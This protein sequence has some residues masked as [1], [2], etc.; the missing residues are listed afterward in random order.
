MPPDDQHSNH[1]RRSCA[2][3]R[4]G[5]GGG[6]PAASR[7][8]PLTSSSPPA[9]TTT[10][11]L[12]LITVPTGPFPDSPI[13]DFVTRSS[14]QSSSIRCS[15]STTPNR[16]PRPATSSR[17]VADRGG[18]S[19]KLTE[20]FVTEARPRA[21]LADSGVPARGARL[22]VASG[23][24]RNHRRRGGVST[25]ACAAALAVVPSGSQQRPGARVAGRPAVADSDRKRVAAAPRAIDVGE[26]DA[27]AVRRRHR[28][29]LRR[30][31]SQRAWIATRRSTAS[32]DLRRPAR[33]A[34]ELSSCC[35]CRMA[36][37]AALI[38]RDCQRTA[39]R[40]WRTHR[41]DHHGRRPAGPHHDGSASR[42]GTMWGCRDC[43]AAAS[44]GWC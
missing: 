32:R 26:F 8:S 28:R 7:R 38:V 6:S 15:S 36:D 1:L 40:Q 18:Q 41:A 27:A 2:R 9:S 19:Q 37:A 14:S 43:S 42:S 24:R 21:W 34:V 11:S 35:S 20:V 29:R 44:T 22:V 39:V 33:R 5:R 13:T 30:G 23:R 17:R 10:M 16:R 3:V 4:R 12:T 25:A 31:T